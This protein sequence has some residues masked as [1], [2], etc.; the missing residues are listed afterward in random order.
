[1]SEL[2]RNTLAPW[3][4]AL[5]A[6]VPPAIVALY[7]LKLKRQPLEVPSTYLWKKSIEDLHVNSL[8]QKLRQNLLM[9]LQLLLVG[10]AILALLRPG[11]QGTK[12]EGNRF[13]F[14]VDNSESMSATDAADAPTRLD[15][16]KRLV[17]SLIDQM[18]SS[19]T[20]MIISFADRPQV[21]QEFTENR[22]LLR[23]RL[24]SIE[25]TA[26][27]TDLHGALELAGGL[28]NPSRITADQGGQEVDVVEAQP[29][30]AYIFSDGRFEAVKSFSLGNLKPVY[31]PIGSFD[32]A[33]L[34]ITTLAARRNES[35]PEE[36]QAFVQV[37]NFTDKPQKATVELALDGQFLDAR[38]VEIPAGESAGAVFPLENRQAGG[39]TARLKYQLAGGGSHDALPE[40]DVAYAALGEATHGKVLVVTPGD[41]A[42]EVAIQTEEAK[43]L[44]DV[45]V[46]PPSILDTADYNRDALDGAYNLIVYDQCAPRELPRA[47]TLF[48]G[49]LPPGP[50]W[51]GGGREDAS[52][53]QADKKESG[54]SD[55][56]QS[57]GVPQIID[58]DRAHPLLAHVE[59]GNVD[60][61]DSLVLRPPAGATVL[62]E[63][64]AGPIAAIA[65]RESYQDAVLG[66]ELV[67]QDSAGARTVNTNWPRRHS[68]PTFCLNVLENLAGTADEVEGNSVRPGRS[69]ELHA[70]GTATELTVI[71]P[72]G[73][74]Q[75]VPRSNQD[76]FPFHDTEAPGVYQVRQGD[77]VIQRFAV[78]LFDRAES[79]IRVVPSQDGVGQTIR[80]ADI[81]IGHVDVAASVGRAPARHE[82]WKT[83]L[84][85]ALVVLVLEWYI[86]NRRVYL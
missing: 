67:G 68:F 2:F 5:V 16:A 11:W 22:R 54:N 15:E 33:N 31:V 1:M 12:L 13:I 56:E 25:P 6:L 61:A 62:I 55:A 51:R 3:Q 78:N 49:R 63:A 69:I 4:W 71:D 23:E 34:A 74:A 19:M 9:F 7:F 47:S 41:V 26:R 58:W 53:K 40:D 46:A 66:F 28:A 37:A 64:T 45:R 29:A 44:A 8:W 42:L 50:A 24:A 52:G 14:L 70:A 39:L 80:A 85:A 79:N 30:T 10:L 21:M 65:P 77:Q 73:H 18:D 32:A 57:V 59:L 84:L 72:K 43:Q 76:A 38:E 48:I 75:T 82:T 81:Q 60:I 35:R 27:S 20:A 86:Y 83:L 36:Q 17:G